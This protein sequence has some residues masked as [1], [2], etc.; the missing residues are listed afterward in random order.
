MRAIFNIVLHRSFF[1]QVATLAHWKSYAHFDATVKTALIVQQIE[2]FCR[3]NPEVAGIVL[4]HIDDF[5][6]MCR[7]GRMMHML[8]TYTVHVHAHKIVSRRGGRVVAPVP[9]T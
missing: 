9:T 3:A 7:L 2:Y 4:D 8:E 6:T 1:E 5:E